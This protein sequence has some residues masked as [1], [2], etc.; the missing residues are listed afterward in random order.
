M[1]K[2]KREDENRIEKKREKRREGE[3]LG[4]LGKREKKIGKK[5]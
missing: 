5:I 1:T 4:Q 3:G 2:R